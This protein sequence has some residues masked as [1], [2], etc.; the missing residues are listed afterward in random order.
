MVITNRFRANAPPDSPAA[1]LLAVL[2]REGQPVEVASVL[3]MGQAALLSA[4]T[5]QNESPETIRRMV[6]AG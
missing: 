5:G 4:T 1:E 3:A 2:Q 6:R